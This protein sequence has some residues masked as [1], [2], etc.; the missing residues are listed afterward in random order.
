MVKIPSNSI[1]RI[2]LSRIRFMGDVILT[3]PLIRQLREAFPHAHLAYLVEETYAPLL[4]HNPHLDEIL[5]LS[6][7]GKG[8][9]QIGLIRTLRSRRFDLAIDLF[10]N[11][12]TALLT[13]LSGARWRVGGDFRGRG[14]LY[15]I[16][17][18]SSAEKPDAI[19]FHQRSLQAIGLPPGDKNTEIFLTENEIAEAKSFLQRQGL[20]ANR[21]IAGLHPGATWPNKRW[22]IEYFVELAKKLL[23]EKIQIFVTCG[24]GEQALVAPFQ[25]IDDPRLVVGEV[26]SLRQ[27]AAVLAHFKLH[28]SNDCGVMHLAAA[29]GTPTFGIFGPGEP[30]IWFPYAAG[31]GHRAFWADIECRPCHKDFC[32]L[33]TLACMHETPPNTVFRQAMALLEERTISQ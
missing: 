12:R 3:T 20:A 16:R 15:N 5:P 17:V 8:M 11:P 4:E 29:V 24:P 22:P 2:L 10:G 26:L 7:S 25:K 27:L 18:P 13:W 14:K 33:G 28:I 9:Q 23:A 1:S 31:D 19:A 32:P 21:A 30:E 6:L